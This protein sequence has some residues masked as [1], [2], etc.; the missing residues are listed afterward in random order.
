MMATL[1]AATAEFDFADQIALISSELLRFRMKNKLRLSLGERTNLEKLEMN[2]DKATAK[3]RAKGIAALGS[4]TKK[5]RSEV[6]E[7]TKEAEIFLKKIKTIEKVIDVI[8]SILSLG[9]AITSGG[10]PLAILNAAKAV[11]IASTSD[12]G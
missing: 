2:L 8:T 10:T 12:N 6:E 3:V 9:L 5:A 1:N 11:K 4:L 7:A